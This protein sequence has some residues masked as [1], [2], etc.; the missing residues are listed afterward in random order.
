MSFAK[1]GLPGDEAYYNI[2]GTGTHSI[3][4]LGAR[5]NQLMD[6]G[7]VEVEKQSHVVPPSNI[8]SCSAASTGHSLGGKHIPYIAA[9]V[10]RNGEI[11]SFGLENSC[12][13]YFRITFRP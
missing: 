3:K 4:S 6:L 11:L 13:P 9:Q 7:K 12:I 8:R 1:K 5:N 10:W 2:P